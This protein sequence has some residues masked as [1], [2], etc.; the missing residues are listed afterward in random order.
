MNFA[1]LLPTSDPS[2]RCLHEYSSPSPRDALS[3]IKKISE[4]S[5]KQPTSAFGCVILAVTLPTG[6]HLFSS[7][8][9]LSLCF[10]KSVFEKKKRERREMR[11]REVEGEKKNPQQTKKIIEI[12]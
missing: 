9:I 7:G 2:E 4:A 5:L 6:N 10:L 11:T 12:K 8:G 1:M 3:K